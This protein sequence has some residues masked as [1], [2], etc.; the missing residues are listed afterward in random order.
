MIPSMALVVGFWVPFE[1][2][3]NLDLGLVKGILVGVYLTGFTFSGVMNAFGPTVKYPVYSA[4]HRPFADNVI[5]RFGDYA[6]G[7]TGSGCC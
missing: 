1:R 6:H 2:S 7:N 4:Y 5:V 3:G